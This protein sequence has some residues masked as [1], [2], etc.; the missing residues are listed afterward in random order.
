[1]S[2]H[3]ISSTL[4]S[5]Q[6]SGQ[7]FEHR[8]IIVLV[9]AQAFLGAQLP[10]MTVLSGLAGQTLAT[11]ICWATLPVTAQGFGSMTSSIWMSRLMQ[12]YGR[13]T[14]FLVGT[15]AGATGASIAACGL[16]LASFPL[17]VI[18][19]FF[20]GI[21]ASA[22]GFYRFAAMDAVAESYRPKA[23]SLVL[24][25]GLAA[26]IFGT[27]VSKLTAELMV[28]PFLGTYIAVIAINA[29]GAILFLFLR[30]PTSGAKGTASGKVRGYFQL[31]KDPLIL[32]A[33]MCA[34]VSF[35]MMILVMTSTPLAVVGV[36]C[37][38]A[39]AA[40]IVMAHVLAMFL[41]S[42]FTGHLISRYGTEK[43]V[44]LGLILLTAAGAVNLSG[45]EV[46]NFYVG[47]VL[48][49]LGWNFGFIG[50]TAMLA[51]AHSKAEQGKV[52]GL[53]DMLVAAC[54]TL[55]SFASGSLMNCSG[56]SVVQG[57]TAVNLATLPFLTLAITALLFPI[58]RSGFA[59]PAGM[60]LLLFR[61]TP[62]GFVEGRRGKFGIPG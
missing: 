56:N 3:D 33:Y 44:T 22:Q 41:P 23:M 1:M 40:D 35:G 37:S 28:V 17:F 42:F 53:N 50:A 54:V 52:Q 49:G 16:V 6:L 11:N 20:T 8:N 13:R 31:L 12:R 38:R 57:W 18:G 62:F 32:R 29:I 10:M 58:L 19:A 51:G 27:Q 7:A 5:T 46:L 34:M 61:I 4:A 2:R 48:L 59:V 30:I 43:I 36:G 39:M 9:V 15:L 47:L 26:A 45:M 55:A 60:R 14:G 25:G 24:A 21:Y